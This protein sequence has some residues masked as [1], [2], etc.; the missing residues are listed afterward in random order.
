MGNFELFECLSSVSVTYQLTWGIEQETETVNVT[1]SKLTWEVE[2]E[3]E[4]INVTCQLT[5]EVE[6]ES[7]DY[8]CDMSAYM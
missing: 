3:A 5:W 4:T 2:Q 7:L 6:R 8:Q 1:C